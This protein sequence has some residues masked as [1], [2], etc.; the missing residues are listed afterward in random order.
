[1]DDEAAYPRFAN[2]GRTFVYVLPCRDEDVLKIGFSRDPL[3]RFRTLHRRFFEFFDLQRG[4]LVH[5]DH[6]RDARRLERR[7]LTAFPHERTPAPLVV[8]VSAA[9]HTEWFRG[10]SPQVEALV[11]QMCVEEGLTLHAPLS[12]WLRDRLDDGSERAFDWST[13]MLE[14]IEFEHFNLPPE[15]RGGHAASALRD[16][17]DA[18]AALGLDVEK[19]VPVAVFSW[20]RDG[21]YFGER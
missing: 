13:R 15:Q 21:G 11:R 19:L 9:G 6:L 10:V 20:Y 16:L 17:L 4:L 7:L 2:R 3:A 12:D 18:Y 14:A 5:A 1:M 8:P